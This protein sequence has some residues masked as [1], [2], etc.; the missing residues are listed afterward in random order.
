MDE[1]ALHILDIVQNSLAAGATLV[2][3]RINE[4]EDGYVVFSIED[5]GHGMSQE[6]VEKVQDPFV[7]TRTTRKVGMGIPLLA[8]TAEQSG[9]GIELTSQLGKGTVITARFLKDHI[10]RPPMGDIINTLKVLLVTNPGLHLILNYSVKKARFVFDTAE[11]EEQ[12]GCE[13]DYSIPDIYGW[14]SDFLQQEISTV[15]KAGR[16]K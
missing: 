9:G 3:I 1:L 16:D 7:T 2:I 15:R 5:N 12:L 13:V 6:M 11:V 10:D 4:D 14:L 8:M